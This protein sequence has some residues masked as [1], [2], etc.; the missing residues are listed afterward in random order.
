VQEQIASVFRM[1]DKIEGFKTRLEILEG[2]IPKMFHNITDILIL[3]VQP[4]PLLDI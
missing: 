1:A 2:R 3:A 4:M